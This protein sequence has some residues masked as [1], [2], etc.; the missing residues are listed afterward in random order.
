MQKNITFYGISGKEYDF[1]EKQADSNWVHR[2]GAAVFATR[3]AYGWR[4]IKISE[5]SGR[6]HDV[7]PIWAFHDAQRFGADTVFVSEAVDTQIRRD[8]IKD[9]EAGLDP[10]VLSDEASLALAA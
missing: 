4:V 2:A 3:G 5:L 6:D 1:V 9:M 8:M 7:R 10:V